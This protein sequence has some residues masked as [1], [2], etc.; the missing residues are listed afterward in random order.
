MI[1]ASEEY[2]KAQ[3]KGLDD[4]RYGELVALANVLRKRGGQSVLDANLE[5]AALAAKV[6]AQFASSTAQDTAEPVTD[7]VVDMLA[8][9][10]HLCHHFDS[11]DEGFKRL[12]KTA[13]HHFEAE[14]ASQ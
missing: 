1:K 11:Q 7:I 4:A 9:V 14:I 5:R 2:Q 10:M 12:L 3:G 6:L 8:N 13:T